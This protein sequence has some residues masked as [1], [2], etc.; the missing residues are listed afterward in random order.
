MK[1]EAKQVQQELKQGQAWPVYWVYGPERLQVRELVALLRKTIVG[2]NAWAEERLD[3]ASLGGQ[4]VVAAAQSIPFGGGLRFVVVRDAH[5]IREPDAMAELFGP[6]AKIEELSFVC[7][8]VS[9]DLDAR[10]KFSKQLIEKAAVVECAAIPEQQRETWIQYLAG[11][12][13]L[14]SRSLPLNT[15]VRAEPW[16]L[17]WVESELMKWALAEEVQAGLGEEVLVGGAS[18]GMSSEQFIDAFLVRRNLRDALQAVETLGRKPEEALP[19]LGLLTWNVRMLAL[20]AARSRA[21]KLPPFLQEKLMRALRVWS[22]EEIQA[23]QSALSDLDFGFKQTPQEPMA[24]WG[25]LIS[26]FCPN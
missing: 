5:L 7:V 2:E 26:R 6:R 19:L 23:L 9:K 16:S 25:V 10:R 1:L 12:L 24:L 17:E 15:L 13:G 8:L 18:S 14:K 21:V 3:G 20:L 4:D 11:T 22:L